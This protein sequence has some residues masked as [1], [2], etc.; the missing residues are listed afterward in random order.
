MSEDNVI[1]VRLSRKTMEA[2][3]AIAEK[4]GWEISKLLSF[5]LTQFVVQDGTIISGTWKKKG[6]DMGRKVIIDWPTFPST[7]T[8][9]EIMD[10]PFEEMR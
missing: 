3:E 5:V 1:S 8:K 2:W 6:E 7:I 10:V 9:A 4:H